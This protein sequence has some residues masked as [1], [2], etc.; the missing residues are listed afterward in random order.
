MRSSSLQHKLMLPLLLTGVLLA[1]A[2]TVIATYI[3]QQHLR[4]YVL[5][6]AE[7][8]ASSVQLAAETYDKTSEIH[9]VVTALGA[10]RDVNLIV[11]VF[12]NP[13]RVIASTRNEWLGL[14]LSELP[15]EGVADDLAE[16]IT[17]RV[18]AQHV[19]RQ[20]HELDFTLPL[21]RHEPGSK[22][23]VMGAAMVH[24]SAQQLTRDVWWNALIQA[25][26]TL[27]MTLLLCVMM[28]WVLRR[29]VLKPA[30]ELQKVVQAQ[31]QGLRDFYPQT[32]SD[33]E[34]GRVARELDR[35]LRFRND[36]E[37]Q[38]T[39]S[40]EQAETA[41]NEVRSAQQRLQIATRAGGFGIWDWDRQTDHMIWDDRMYE[42]F[43]RPRQEPV[44]SAR[45][46]Q[47][48]LSEA[49]YERVTAAID[50]AIARRDDGFSME[51]VM[52]CTDGRERRLR[53]EALFVRNEQGN[54]VRVIGIMWDISAQ[55][56]AQ[57]E[58][59][60]LA[61]VAQHAN[62]LIVIT[63]RQFDVEWVNNAFLRFTGYAVSDILGEHPLRKLQGA[64]TSTQI[65]QQLDAAIAQRAV[66]HTELLLYR[67][68]GQPFWA[69]LELLPVIS[70]GHL[71]RFILI[72]NVVTERIQAQQQLQQAMIRA[73]LASRS[74]SEFL[75]N[76]SHEIRTPMNAILGLS[77]ML[78]DTTLDEQQR[79]F[80]NTIYTAG[81]ALLTII[82]DILDFSKIEAGKLSLQPIAFDLERSLYEVMR[83]LSIRAQEKNIELVLDY[84]SGAPKRLI[85]DPV[86]MRQVLLNL[87]GNAVKFTHSGHVR[88]SVRAKSWDK[89]TA[90]LRIEVEDTGIGID[91]ETQSTLFQ[92]FTQAD[93]SISRQYG[94][95]GLGLA[96][97][98]RIVELMGG[99]IGLI[100]AIGK[101]STFF[102]DIELPLA[103]QQSW[104]SQSIALQ[105]ETVWLMEPHALA[106]LVLERQLK[107]CGVNVHV[108]DSVDALQRALVEL[109]RET[110]FVDSDVARSADVLSWWKAQKPDAALVILSSKGVRGE[111]AQYRD[112]PACAYLHKPTDSET[113]LHSLHMVLMARDQKDMPLITK[114]VVDEQ[115]DNSSEC[116]FSAQVLVAEDVVANQM[117][118]RAML[119]RCG[120]DVTFAN[121]GVEAVVMALRQPFDLILMDCQ[122]PLLDGLSATQ[123]I[124]QQQPVRIPIVALTANALQDDRGRCLD[125]GMDDFLSKPV[126]RRQLIDMLKK[127]L[128]H[129]LHSKA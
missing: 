23:V 81:D 22:H 80:V 50:S 56:D 46:L 8:L 16:A 69:E 100:S 74:K 6:R 91:Q 123:Q 21:Q 90:A 124:R 84:D 59:R 126:K 13:A 64:D 63:N 27:L 98:K 101:G 72:A 54:V 76:M 49:E 117:V 68:N 93:A 82:N 57:Q 62:N 110:L 71:D 52:R 66:M 107:N 7:T 39:R 122:M 19:H 116:Q 32:H 53:D 121:N 4:E 118:I 44:S 18:G 30:A 97:S 31:A 77:E 11:V 55:Y 65:I 73:E 26:V 108:I 60:K 33:D 61:L 129:K 83:M 35:L 103:P 47:H 5:Q 2:S 75:A 45:V 92:S 128:P 51:F 20:T 88:A 111:A 1:L 115:L 28:W 17:T 34:L 67:R 105:G 113:L 96:I 119:Q 29:H 24:I 41:F 89:N 14:P 10:E 86:R 112:I 109:K 79:D 42:L 40:R 3:Y 78:R 106:R 95:T 70:D 125:A 58:Q 43:D 114:H 85:A 37:W 127:W 99:T 15:Y 102:V 38:L 94:G 9:R 104:P 48:Y 25:S 120:I 12:G 36:A 87:L